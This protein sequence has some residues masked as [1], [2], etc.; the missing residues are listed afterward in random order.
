MLAGLPPEAIDAFVEIGGH[1]SGS[2]LLILELRHLGGA[3]GRVPQNAGALCRL[4]AP[5]NLFALGVPVDPDVASAIMHRLEL[6]R[7][8]MAPFVTGGAYLNFAERPT[9]T[10]AAFSED[11]YAALQAVKAVLDPEGVIQANHEIP[12]AG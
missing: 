2:P 8:A 7:G 9:H 10:A 5:Y 4:D 6:V 3:L 1:E 11:A 12:A